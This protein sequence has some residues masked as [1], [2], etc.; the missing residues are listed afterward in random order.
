MLKAGDIVVTSCRQ[1]GRVDRV[2]G[3]GKGTYYK[4][5]LPDGLILNLYPNNVRLAGWWEK[6]EKKTEKSKVNRTNQ[7]ISQRIEVLR[8]KFEKNIAWS[9][10]E[11]IHQNLRSVY[12]NTA[13]RYYAL[14]EE[15]EWLLES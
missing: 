5:K 12:L 7:E 2:E 9:K 6:F 8:K 1:V 15:Y 14:I 11:A 10:D 13:A 4:V 3:F